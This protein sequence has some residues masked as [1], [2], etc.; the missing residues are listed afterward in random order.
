MGHNG[1]GGWGHNEGG[2]ETGGPVMVCPGNWELGRSGLRAR[3]PGEGL[4]HSGA[5][6][7]LP[8]LL[9]LS[10]RWNLTSPCH[11]GLSL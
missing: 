4:A 2:E 8:A 3:A 10:R 1:V 5:L 6:G 7:L 9:A 11:V